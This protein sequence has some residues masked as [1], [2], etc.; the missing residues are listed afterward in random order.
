MRWE[1]GNEKRSAHVGTGDV[2]VSVSGR[3]EKAV[4][5]ISGV[6]VGNRKINRRLLLLCFASLFG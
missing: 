5:R 1:E 2:D 4:G 6:V 3:A